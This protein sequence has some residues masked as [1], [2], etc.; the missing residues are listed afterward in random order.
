MMQVSPLRTA[1][2][3][4]DRAPRRH[5]RPQ[6]VRAAARPA[7][8]PRS[9]HR[10]R[11]P[12]APLRP[13][14]RR[15]RPCGPAG[16]DRRP[17]VA[18]PRP[19]QH[20]QRRARPRDGRRSARGRRPPGS[21]SSCLPVP[22]LA[23]LGGDEFV[24]LCEGLPATRPPARSRTASSTRSM[25]AAGRRGR[26]VDRHHQHRGGARQ[27]QDEWRGAAPPGRRRHASRQTPRPE[28]IRVLRQATALRRV[29]ATQRGSRV[30]PRD[31]T[32]R[33]Q[34]RLPAD[35]R[36][37]HWCDRRGR[38]AAALAA[39]HPGPVAARRL[40]RRRRG[41]RAARAGRR[42]GVARSVPP[43]ARVERCAARRSRHPCR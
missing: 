29:H 19:V 40:P 25:T 41:R 12:G 1:T 27:P 17:A 3:G 15:D 18:R 30:A 23:R 28:A 10:S 16:L 2:G 4:A 26:I 9:P 24:V 36:H 34:A 7:G 6:G 42:L 32:L 39:P 22:P 20:R 5:H 35:R 14:R 33:V 11:Q 31:R 13:P 8:A 21:A 38:G 43:G 37:A